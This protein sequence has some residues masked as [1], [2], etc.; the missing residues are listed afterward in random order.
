MTKAESLSFSA[1]EIRCKN[2]PKNG[3]LQIPP[4]KVLKLAIA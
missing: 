1:V 4:V 3:Y 2:M